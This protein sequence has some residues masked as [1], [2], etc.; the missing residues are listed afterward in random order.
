M[1]VIYVHFPGIDNVHVYE[2]SNKSFYVLYMIKFF[3]K[4]KFVFIRDS[5]IC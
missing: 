3:G 1:N 4:V 2:L 5:M